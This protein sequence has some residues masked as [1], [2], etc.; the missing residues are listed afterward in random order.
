MAVV[1]Q[2]PFVVERRKGT[3]DSGLAKKRATGRQRAEEERQRSNGPASSSALLSIADDKA[4]R[5]IGESE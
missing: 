4:T 2:K 5:R 1:P 3:I